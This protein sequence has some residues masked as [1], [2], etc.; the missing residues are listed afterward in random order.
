M[1]RGV[2][3]HRRRRTA[4]RPPRAT[5]G[6]GSARCATT[7]RPL[8]GAATLLE[9]VRGHW[10]I[11]NGLHRT[12]DMQFREDDCRMRTGN[13]P[14]VMGIL[15][16][17]VLNMIRTMQRKLETD[18]SIGLLRDRIERHPGSWPPHCPK[19]DFVFAL[20]I[21]HPPLVQQQPGLIHQTLTKCR[22]DTPR[23]W[24]CEPRATLK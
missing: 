19:S 11:E 18:V 3:S 5:A 24:A 15:R 12:L 8:R 2:P 17:T 21:V 22:G 1:P 9:L 13:A 14:A 23:A 4:A 20:P 7:S 16:R 6:A 10:S